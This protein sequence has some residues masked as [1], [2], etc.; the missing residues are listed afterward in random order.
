MARVST[1]M[2]PGTVGV[3]DAVDAPSKVIASAGEANNHAAHGG[4]GHRISRKNTVVQCEAG[5]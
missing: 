5:V 3:G 4:G 2:Q 1:A